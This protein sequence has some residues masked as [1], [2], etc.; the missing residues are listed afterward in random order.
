MNKNQ[1]KLF[2]Y[3]FDILVWN[4]HK[5]DVCQEIHFNYCWPPQWVVNLD[6]GLFFKWQII[7]IQYII[8]IAAHQFRYFNKMSF[9]DHR[10]TNPNWIIQPKIRYDYQWHIVWSICNFNNKKYAFYHTNALPMNLFQILYFVR[11]CPVYQLKYGMNYIDYRLKILYYR[12]NLIKKKVNRKSR[13]VIFPRH[14]V[15]SDRK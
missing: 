12:L 1:K 2:H 13:K 6:F 14:K 11:F 10:M 7:D 4:S 3:W 9:L 5:T 15:N 8:F